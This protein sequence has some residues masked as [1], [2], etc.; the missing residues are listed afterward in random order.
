M[1]ASQFSCKIKVI[2]KTLILIILFFCC[3]DHICDRSLNVVKYHFQT[4]II[5]NNLVNGNPEYFDHDTLTLTSH[6][7]CY[8]QE[9]FREIS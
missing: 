7:C 6:A 5:D 2:K 3:L 1:Y 8:G 9:I 4:K